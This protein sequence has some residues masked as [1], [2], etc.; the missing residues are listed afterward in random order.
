[1]LLP[2]ATGGELC[3]VLRKHAPLSLLD[4]LFYTGTVALIFEFLHDRRIVYR[5]LKPENLMLD[6]DG[7]AK[8][9]GLGPATST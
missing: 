1:M 9:I 7:C 5:D 2:M 8:I 6:N 4:A 3:S